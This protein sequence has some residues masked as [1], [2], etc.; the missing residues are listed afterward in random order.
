MLVAFFSLS[1]SSISIIKLLLISLIHDSYLGY[2]MDVVTLQV[3]Q[4]Y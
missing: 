2:L 1:L 4:N 3:L